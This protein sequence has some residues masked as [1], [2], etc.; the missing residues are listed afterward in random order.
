MGAKVFSTG[1]KKYHIFK[2][3]AYNIGDNAECLLSIK[4]TTAGKA[5]ATLTYD[6]GKKKKGKK[7]YYKPSCST[8]VWQVTPAD[9]ATF[10]GYVYLYFA[11]SAG[12]NFP[13]W[14]TAL[15]TESVGAGY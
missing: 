14:E 3:L 2:K 6:T 15:N 13:G 1:K 5:T 4:V 7:V 9:P 8:V 11:P 12:N 10:E